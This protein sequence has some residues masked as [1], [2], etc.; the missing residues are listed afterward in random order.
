MYYFYGKVNRGHVVCPL[1]RGGPYLGESVMEDSTVYLSNGLVALAQISLV[2]AMYYM[3]MYYMHIYYM[4]T[5][6][7]T[8]IHH[9]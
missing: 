7:Y 2:H 9:C 8:Y 4:H 6:A 3:H 5:C 1:Y